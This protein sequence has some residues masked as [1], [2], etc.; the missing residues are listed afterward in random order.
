MSKVT[1]EMVKTLRERTGVGMSK[2]KAAL[3]EAG[4][5]MDRA[6]DNLRKAG[7]ATAVKKEGRESNEGLIHFAESDDGIAVVELACETDFVAQNEKFKE[8]LNALCQE[9]LKAKPASVEELV[10]L[11]HSGAP[12]MSIEEVRAQLVL[13]LGENIQIK[14]VAVIPKEGGRSYGVYS[15]MG[16]RIFVLIELGGDTDQGALAK[17][18]A[19]HTAA[20]APEYLSPEDVPAD[21]IEREKEVA[22]GQIGDKPEYVIDKILQGK[23]NSF[24]EQLCLSHQKF[25]KDPSM[26]ITKLLEEAG[27]KAGQPIQL[28][29]FL[30]W[31]IGG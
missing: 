4:G 23:L 11:P 17:D 8:F 24:Y 15:H 31:Q 5:D 9:T 20:E 3:D 26:T 25:V 28:V 19:M 13:S 10:K 21:I 2:C 16:G 1:A 7:M 14:R 6:I 12:G 18:I 22:K 29:Q 27:K 30:R